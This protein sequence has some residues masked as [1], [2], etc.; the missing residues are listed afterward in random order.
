MQSLIT[1]AVGTRTFELSSDLRWLSLKT[2]G[3]LHDAWIKQSSR[4]IYEY[5]SCLRI[6]PL[7]HVHQMAR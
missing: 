1:A 2:T 4:Q 7:K 5:S 6:W 3:P